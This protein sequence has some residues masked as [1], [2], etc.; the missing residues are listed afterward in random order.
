MSK[1]K[2]IS[3]AAL[4]ACIAG[5]AGVSQAT[6]VIDYD[7]TTWA[8]GTAAWTD[9]TAGLAAPIG[10]GVPVKSTATIG[11]T[12]VDIV[13]FNGSS[14]FDVNS[15]THPLVGLKQYSISAVF[16]APQAAAGN[17]VS[18]AFFRYQGITG[19]ELAGQGVGD[20]GLGLANGSAI[21][22]G[23]ALSTVDVGTSGPAVNDNTFH[24]V[25]FTVMNNG[26]GTFSQRLYLDGTE[27]DNDL[28]VAYGTTAANP[29]AIAATNFAIGA[30]R[31]GA[32]GVAGNSAP[33]FLG[34]LA[35]LQFD[36][37]P[38]TAAQVSAQARNFLGEAVPEPASLGLLGLAGLGLFNRR[39]RA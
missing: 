19:K 15:T 11:T 17:G 27:R 35:R 25:A 1:N 9:S 33:F 21:S 18:D 7:A 2:I 32:G 8:G 16:R 6:L 30:I 36:N 13:A 3:A 38:L 23:T 22:G 34:D 5:T 28:N 12:P 37:Q 4:A 31:A 29:G 20:F 24:T 26:D 14:T 10:T 39:R